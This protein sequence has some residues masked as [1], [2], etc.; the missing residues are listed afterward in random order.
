MRHAMLF[1]VCFGIGFPLFA[2]S[3]ELVRCTD[4][5]G[6]YSFLRRGNCPSPTDIQTPVKAIAANEKSAAENKPAAVAV[7]QPQN[8]AANDDEATRRRVFHSRRRR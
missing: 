6:K 7:E 1:V 3:A 5:D 4:P 2:G 8:N